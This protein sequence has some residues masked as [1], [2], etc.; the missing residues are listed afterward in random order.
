[1]TIEISSFSY[2]FSVEG[3][4]GG[5]SSFN[6]EMTP[7]ENIG[8]NPAR[9]TSLMQD[10]MDRYTAMLDALFDADVLKG[11]KHP[12]LVDQPGSVNVGYQYKGS[13]PNDSIIRGRQDIEGRIVDIFGA[14][15]PDLRGDHSA[16]QTHSAS[17]SFSGKKDG[18]RVHSPKIELQVNL[19]HKLN[20]ALL[21]F[22]RQIPDVD[23][24]Q[25]AALNIAMLERTLALDWDREG[26]D[27]YAEL[28]RV[29]QRP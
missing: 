19:D 25:N 18:D 1:M 21:R 12:I 26:R 9:A 14:P 16:F 3:T 15:D 2:Y 28:K 27:H 20:V 13:Y 29:S 4:T 6:L 8:N 11:E 22:N 17:V 24:Q 5:L 10:M 23:T 7:T